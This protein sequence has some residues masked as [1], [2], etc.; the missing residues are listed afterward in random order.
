MACGAGTKS[1]P[2]KDYNE[3]ALKDMHAEVLARR[4]LIRY[5]VKC[6]LKQDD[7]L[8]MFIT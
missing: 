6:P 4:A 5:L 7:K 8:H 1:L 2:K 3:Y